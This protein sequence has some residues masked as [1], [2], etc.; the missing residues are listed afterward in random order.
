MCTSFR[1]SVGI[2]LILIIA[3]FCQRIDAQNQRPAK[4]RAPDYGLARWF[5]SFWE[6]Y[7]TP[8]H[9]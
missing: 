4:A 3:G 5:P 1:R 2:L 6:P 9:P 8:T 7:S